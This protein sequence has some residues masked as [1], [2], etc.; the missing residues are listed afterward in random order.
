MA[1]RV[2]PFRPRPTSEPVPTAD[3]L[4]DR[5]HWLA[6]DSKNLR[7]DIPHFQERLRM[8]KLTMRQVLDTLRHGNVISGPVKDEWGDWRVKLKRK[9][10]GR[11]VQVVVAVK[12]R[13]LVV[14][15]VI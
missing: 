12:E 6:K 1:D 9:V 11:R 14:V 7:F 15:T 3:A 10:A 5:V 2:V 8:R 13:H 4:E